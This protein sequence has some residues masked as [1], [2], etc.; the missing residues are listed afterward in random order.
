MSAFEAWLLLLTLVGILAGSWAIFWARNASDPARRWWGCCLFV[1]T[2]LELGA[3]GMAA[4]WQRADGL[5]PLGLSA[6]F[7]VVGMLWEGPAKRHPSRLPD[8][9]C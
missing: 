5:V 7:L 2:L 9:A 4:A 3:G 1:I 6:G 8:S